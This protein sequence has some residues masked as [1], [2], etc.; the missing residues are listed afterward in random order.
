[1]QK[2]DNFYS[3]VYQC[4]EAQKTKRRRC[5]KHCNASLAANYARK[6]AINEQVADNALIELLCNFDQIPP[7]HKQ[8]IL[9][10][11]G[12]RKLQKSSP[13]YQTQACIEFDNKF[14]S[15]TLF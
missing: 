14:R 12:L 4:R 13:E 1:M 7:Q 3:L 8:F 9:A 11:E 6:A 10:F 2:V 15:S 5:T